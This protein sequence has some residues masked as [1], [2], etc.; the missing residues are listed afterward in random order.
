[1][2][3][4]GLRKLCSRS[5]QSSVGAVA[6]LVGNMRRG[7]VPEAS[8][9]GAPTFMPWA[10]KRVEWLCIFAAEVRKRHVGAPIVVQGTPFETSC[11]VMPC[12]GSPRGVD[13]VDCGRPASRSTT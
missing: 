13:G 2:Q 10:K 6:E 12:E 4:G 3:Q 5:A 11:A 8:V 9:L 1:M 7:V